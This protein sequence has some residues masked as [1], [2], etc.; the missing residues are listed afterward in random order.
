[1]H[2]VWIFIW[3]IGVFWY[4]SIW[5]SITKGG[6]S[7]DWRSRE[8]SPWLCQF[9]LIDPGVAVLVEAE[10]LVKKSRLMFS[11]CRW[12]QWWE[13]REHRYYR[14]HRANWPEWPGPGRLW[15]RAETGR[16]TKLRER[17]PQWRRD[18][19]HQ[20]PVLQSPAAPNMSRF[21]TVLF[22]TILY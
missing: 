7:G 10:D 12:G 21:S 5:N 9:A 15:E 19:C 16:S 13:G 17:T 14:A 11:S 4:K 22:C 3:I 8:V 1:M 6:D 18:S 2:V 20:G